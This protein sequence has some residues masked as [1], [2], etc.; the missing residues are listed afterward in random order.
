MADNTS[1]QVQFKMTHLLPFMQLFF[2]KFSFEHH[3]CLFFIYSLFTHE[4]HLQAEYLYLS[5]SPQIC[6]M[7]VSFVILP[8][9]PHIK[10]QVHI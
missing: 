8:I 1:L 10:V 2:F 3:T 6:Y 7:C 4:L 5:D 9:Y